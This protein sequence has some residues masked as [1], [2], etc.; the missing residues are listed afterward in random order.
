MD[1]RD[2]LKNH[3]VK[4]QSKKVKPNKLR[5]KTNEK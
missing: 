4:G 3:V 1:S 2:K 5:K